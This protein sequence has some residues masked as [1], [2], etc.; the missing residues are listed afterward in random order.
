METGYMSFLWLRFLR[1]KDHF[2]GHYAARVLEDGVSY[3][4]GLREGNRIIQ[5][6]GVDVEEVSWS[7]S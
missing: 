7:P 6:N 4:A 5:V 1:K 2:V 3:Q